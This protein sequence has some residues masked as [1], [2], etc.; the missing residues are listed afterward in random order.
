MDRSPSTISRELRK[1]RTPS[2]KYHPCFASQASKSRRWTGLK[3]DRHSVLRKEVLNL[4]SQGLSPEQIAG[5]YRLENGKTIISYET[6]Y[7]FIY[8]QIARTKDYRWRLYLP[9]GKYKRRVRYRGKQRYAGG[10]QNRVSIHSR[11]NDVDKKTEIKHWESDLMHF[12]KQKGVV[13]VTSERKSLYLIASRGPSKKSKPLMRSLKRKLKK[14][15]NEVL[16]S[17]TFD[18]GTEFSEHEGLHSLGMKTYF[19]DIHS[20]WQKGGVENAIRRLRRY[21]PKST[22]LC[23][24]THQRL[25]SLVNRYNRTPRKCLGYLTPEEVFY[26]RVLHFKLE[27]TFPPSRE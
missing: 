11:G 24:W 22:Q 12:A 17:V 9:Q 23:D 3:L 13:H 4:L 26:S 25:H 16:G 1:N 6:I 8:A 21:L 7:Q 20:P 14:L 2:G 15:P 10:I 18:N 19:C 5:R 27:S